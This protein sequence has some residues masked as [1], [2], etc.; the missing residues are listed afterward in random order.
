MLNFIKYKLD[1]KAP[2]VTFIHGAGGSSNIWFKQIRD[3][4]KHFNILL[5]DL[6]GHGNSKNN[7]A[8]L[9]DYSFNALAKDI[10]CVIDFLEIKCTHFVG[11]SLGTI[12]IREIA[13][14]RPD[15]IHKMVLSGATMKLNFRGKFL[16]QL[17]IISQNIVP[18]L[19]LYKFF[20]FII[21]PRKS[22]K[23]S[24]VLFITEAKK[25]AQKEFMRWFKL[26][27]GINYKLKQYRRTQITI[28]TLYIMGDMDYMFLPSIKKLVVLQGSYST[29]HVVPKCG[30]V[31]NIEKPEIFNKQAINF[32]NS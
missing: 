20:A 23:E 16:M 12:L 32:L 21:M 25:L 27:R 14:I 8:E 4:K 30:H 1:E 6:R 5:I 17:G 28:P 26:T 7:L 11:M 15:C 9:Q 18:Y 31:V 22:Q 3:F 29:L 13:E 2:W 19:L 10:I 24:R